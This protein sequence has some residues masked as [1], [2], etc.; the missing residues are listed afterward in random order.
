MLITESKEALV[1]AGKIV[2]SF[3]QNEKIRKQQ[4]SLV[5]SKSSDKGIVQIIKVLSTLSETIDDLAFKDDY[6]YLFEAICGCTAELVKT[7]FERD[8]TKLLADI[9]TVLHGG[10]RTSFVKLCLTNQCIIFNNGEEPTF[11][12][13]AK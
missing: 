3:T 7:N 13:M 10:Q 6:N 4:I 8:L 9:Y 12:K 2:T 1:N 5:V 11:L